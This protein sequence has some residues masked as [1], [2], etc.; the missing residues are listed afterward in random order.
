MTDRTATVLEFV[1]N[2]IESAGYSPTLQ[3]IA[4]GCG[5]SSKGLVR[6]HIGKLVR[7][8]KLARQSNAPRGLA[9]P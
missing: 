2:Y 1:Q 9:L 7:A 5:L 3:E 8:G 6:Y 4:H